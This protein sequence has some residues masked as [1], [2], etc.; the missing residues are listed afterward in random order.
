[1]SSLRR[2]IRSLVRTPGFAI[3]AILTL[4]LA[5]ASIGTLFAVVNAVLLK[6]LPFPDAERIIRIVR[7]Q[8]SCEDCPISRPALFD[9]QQQSSSVFEALGS[10]NSANVTMTGDGD[11]EQLSANR[12]TPQL[13]DVMKVTPVIGRTFTAE[14]DKE[15]R[16][17][18]VISHGFWQRHF[19]GNLAVLGKKI[20]LNGEAHE[21]VGVM[22]AH[23]TYPA[24]DIWLPAQL[25]SAT[26]NRG[27]NYLSVVARLRASATLD[28]AREVMAVITKREAMDFPEEHEALAAKLI[29]LQERVTGTVK[30]A[31]SVMFAASA[32]V[33]LIA[34]ANLANLMLARAQAR[35]RE[36]AMRSALGASRR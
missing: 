7:V 18:A 29:P 14:E 19:G 22:P 10:F 34:C 15:N 26:T 23:F 2:A 16:A 3:V 11:A 24:G 31:L 17:L 12:V 5:I 13:W 27:S 30:P 4:S 28:Q 21:I 25:A 20:T 1:M 9:W 33:L 8:G 36:L 32:M 35:R 6:P